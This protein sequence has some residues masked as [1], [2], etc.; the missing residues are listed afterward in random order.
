VEKVGSDSPVSLEYSDSRGNGQ[1]RMRCPHSNAR[2]IYP[3]GAPPPNS[4]QSRGRDKTVYDR[5]A[6]KTG[7]DD[8]D[9]DHRNKATVKPDARERVPTELE[10]RNPIQSNDEEAKDQQKRM[11]EMVRQ[12]LARIERCESGTQIT[13]TPMRTYMQAVGARPET[14]V[15]QVVEKE[16]D[17]WIKERI[18]P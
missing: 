16:N 4:Q 13:T 14:L 7:H 9:D 10:R 1:N 18:I 6:G 17:S 8:D 5:V 11:D 12:S 3:Q 15:E 2:V